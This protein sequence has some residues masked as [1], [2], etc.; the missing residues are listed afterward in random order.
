MIINAVEC[1]FHVKLCLQWSAAAPLLLVSCQ[2]HAPQTNSMAA[3]PSS[4]QPS[5]VLFGRRIKWVDTQ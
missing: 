2:Q 3:G 4:P 1:A 5:W